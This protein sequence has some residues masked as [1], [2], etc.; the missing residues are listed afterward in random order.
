MAKYALSSWL[1]LPATVT[2]LKLGDRLGLPWTTQRALAMPRQPRRQSWTEAACFPILNR[3]HNRDTLF[4]EEA[5]L[6]YFRQLLHRYRDRLHLRIYHYCLRS[7]HF[8]LLL[9]QLPDA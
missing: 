3:G 8:Q 6:G 2:D 4:A 9:L 5:D 7:N 1:P